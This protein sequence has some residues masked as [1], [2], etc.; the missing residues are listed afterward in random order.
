MSQPGITITAGR[1]R[2]LGLVGLAGLLTYAGNCYSAAQCSDDTICTSGCYRSYNTGHGYVA[3][4]QRNGTT[5][6]IPKHIYVN[7]QE[8]ADA[9]AAGEGW[10]DPCDAT[11]YEWCEDEEPVPL[12]ASRWACYEDTPDGDLVCNNDGAGEDATYFTIYRYEPSTRCLFD[13]VSVYAN[14]QDQAKECVEDDGGLAHTADELCVFM[15]RACYTSQADSAEEQTSPDLSS[16]LD[17]TR[18]IHPAA[19]VFDV[20]SSTSPTGA[21]LP[22]D[23]GLAHSISS[24]PDC[25]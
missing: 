12:E 11:E 3:L 14:S 16:A 6:K 23:S 19:S 21:C 7:D 10:V 20:T 18:S 15:I 5:C 8:D 9:C 13:A 1:L 25:P 2:L 22:L 4:E 17:C 24:I